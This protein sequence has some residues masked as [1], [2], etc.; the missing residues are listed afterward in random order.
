MMRRDLWQPVALSSLIHIVAKVGISGQY[1]YSSGSV[2]IYV[3]YIVLDTASIYTNH[4]TDH[5]CMLFS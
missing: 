5:M 3:Q 2:S 1:V 4:C